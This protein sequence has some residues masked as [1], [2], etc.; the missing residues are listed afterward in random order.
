MTALIDLTDCVDDVY[1]VAVPPNANLDIQLRIANAVYPL[2]RPITERAFYGAALEAEDNAIGVGNPWPEG[3][4]E[5]WLAVVRRM[6]A[7]VARTQLSV[8]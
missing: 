3:Y 8:T 5:R 2:P 7:V 1:H 4:T 6:F